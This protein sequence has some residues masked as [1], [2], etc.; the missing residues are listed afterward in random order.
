VA[1][2]EAVA[3]I[4][5]AARQLGLPASIQG[6]FQGTAQAFQASLA[7]EPLLIAAALVAVYIVLGVLYESYVHPLTIL[8][9]LPSAGVGALLALLLC[10]TELSVIALIGII[11]LIGIVKKNAIM[12]IDFALSAER[13]EG[14][15]PRE[16]IYQACLLRF[17][18]ILMTTLAAL[19][20]ALPLALGTGVGSELRR[21]LGLAIVGGLL[22]SQLLT[23]YTTPVVYLYLDRAGRRLSRLRAPRVLALA[24]TL[25]TLASG[26]AVGPNYVRP[27]VGVPVPAAYKESNGWKTAQPKDDSLRGR[28]WELFGDPGLN[29]LEERVAISNQNVLQAEAQFRQ[30]GALV[31]QARASYFPTVTVGAGVTRSRNA[32]STGGAQGRSTG[33]T[34]EYTLP[35]DVSW[36]LDLWGRIR[37]TVE[38]NR[39]GAQASAADLESA[40]LSAQAEL[41]LDYFQL[42]ALDARKRLLEATIA[43]YQRSLEL[44]RSRYASGVASRAD[45]LQAE[46]QLKTT[47]A[48]AIDVG[49]QRAQFEHAIALLMGEAASSFSLSPAPLD[50]SPPD[51]PVGLPS[52]LLERRPDVAAA[53]RRVAA[54]NAQIGVAEAA[55]FPTVTLS[56]SGGFVASSLAKLL[57]WPARFWSAGPEVSETVFDGGRRRGLTAEARAAYDAA[58]AAYRQTVLTGFQQVEDNL[59]ALRILA[60]E[61]RVQDEA[62]KAAQQ[63]VTLITNQYRAG[64]VSYL[65]VI[66]TQTVALTNEITA[67]E[68][69]GRRMTACVLLIEALGGGWHASEPGP[70]GGGR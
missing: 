23:L 48:E 16:A 57:T 15:P 28:W 39:A 29:R 46:T 21:P 4:E 24:A 63:S 25:L 43:D 49:V 30:A 5:T 69:L 47:Q 10:G 40:R 37:R 26:C 35:V 27:A 51:V 45:V 52:D 56:A 32:S 64:I 68:V 38:S 14:K 41:A 33:T 54:A 58:V 55:F 67:V 7:N 22:V 70:A 9:T 34:T 31:Q 53:E 17:R 13:Q 11:L 50:I 59:A 66:T 18:P 42:R 19:L 6:S 1:L 12:M 62:V 8:S 61:A 2:G 20:G 60:D 3:A 44:T 65:D 36:E